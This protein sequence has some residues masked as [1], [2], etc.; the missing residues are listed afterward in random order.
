MKYFYGMR[1]R[2]FSPG[3]QP[4]E[5]FVKRLDSN[6]PAYHDI[7]VYNKPISEDDVRHYSLTPLYGIDYSDNLGN[8]YLECFALSEDAAV[9]IV[10]KLQF[11][12]DEYCATYPDSDVVWTNRL[13]DCGNISEVY[14]PDSD[15][16][17][18]VE[19]C[20]PI[21]RISEYVKNHNEPIELRKIYFTLYGVNMFDDEDIRTPFL[22]NEE[23]MLSF[24]DR[25]IK[26][27]QELQETTDG[28]TLE[29]AQDFFERNTEDGNA[30]YYGGMAFVYTK[31]RNSRSILFGVRMD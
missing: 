8:D 10:N 4:M 19:L 31:K 29:E 25:Y 20:E 16:Y 11:A 6:V 17:T 24:K 23:K 30:N 14:V 28:M 3:C 1:L 7:I 5:G 12:Y 21:Q 15:C 18:K 22:Y 13:L 9:E 27:I 2:G 26:A